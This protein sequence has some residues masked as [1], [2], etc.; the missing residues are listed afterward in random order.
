[1]TEYEVRHVL[2]SVKSNAFRRILDLTCRTQHDTDV[3]IVEWWYIVI[4]WQLMVWLIFRNTIYY[5]P[6]A[7]LQT[8]T[9][10][11]PFHVVSQKV[12]TGLSPCSWKTSLGLGLCSY[13][14]RTIIRIARST[15]TIIVTSCATICKICHTTNKSPNP[16]RVPVFPCVLACLRMDMQVSVSLLDVAARMRWKLPVSCVFG[17]ELALLVVIACSLLP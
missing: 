13:N 16:P 11:L 4:P 1:M 15:T 3:I 8:S 6:L 14:P 7:S 2:S 9:F 17:S 5:I 12:S 10:K